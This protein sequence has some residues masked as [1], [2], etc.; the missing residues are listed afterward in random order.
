VGIWRGGSLSGSGRSS[1]PPPRP[2]SAGRRKPQSAGRQRPRSGASAA[3]KS[4]LPQIAASSSA[5]AAA[6]E[7]AVQSSYV[8]PAVQPSDVALDNVDD[9]RDQVQF[10]REFEKVSMQQ[11]RSQSEEL[12]EKNQRSLARQLEATKKKEAKLAAKN[13][14]LRDELELLKGDS[15]GADE[16]LA[17]ERLRVQN[18]Q[19]NVASLKT[20]RSGLVREARDAEEA[21]AEAEGQLED[22]RSSLDR[23]VGEKAKLEKKL[24]RE[25]K[26]LKAEQQSSK[27][28]AMEHEAIVRS[29]ASHKEEKSAVAGAK[30]ALEEQWEADRERHRCEVSELLQKVDAAQA[31]TASLQDEYDEVSTR[32]LVLKNRE[33]KR[34][35]VVRC[36]AAVQASL[37]WPEP[38]KP[39]GDT[40]AIEAAASQAALAGL[41]EKTQQAAQTAIAAATPSSGPRAV[42]SAVQR[43]SSGLSVI[44]PNSPIWWAAECTTGPSP[45]ALRSVFDSF[46]ADNSGTIDSSE[47]QKIFAKFGHTLSN[48]EVRA[49]LEVADADGSGE[50]DF[51]EFQSIV[52]SNLRNEL[53]YSAAKLVAVEAATKIQKAFEKKWPR[54]S[55]L[56]QSASAKMTSVAAQALKQHTEAVTAAGVAAAKA[57]GSAIDRRL[58]AINSRAQTLRAVTR[59]DEM[60][61][62]TKIQA[63][64]RGKRGRRMAKGERRER[65]R[66]QEDVAAVK[67]QSA[68]RGRKVRT[69]G[70]TASFFEFSLCLSRACL[71]KMFVFIYKLLKNAVFR[72]LERLSSVK[73]RCSR[74]KRQRE[75]RR[76][77]MPPPLARA[78][79]SVPLV[80]TRR[81]ER[82]AAAA[83]ADLHRVRSCGCGDEVARGRRSCCVRHWWSRHRARSGLC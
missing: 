57:Q 45:R 27:R 61:A 4:G 62:A 19:Q 11:R 28:V 1:M 26:K 50:V 48:V 58:E 9:L 10:A 17:R 72:R 52:A 63:V 30:S 13:K 67:I 12:G 32:Y 47:L 43:K 29:L 15:G 8:V 39:A 21:R 33:A 3:R 64:F 5:A 74:R 14:Q 23:A 75:N 65:K 77:Q 44:R 31:E 35:A 83:A 41:T 2:K 18:L 59:K 69:V 78:R 70:K 76:M 24:A 38:Q 34:K 60:T 82:A 36:E 71:G 25:E 20:E 46:D 79:E 53:W 51:E 7:P 73:R 66:K 22:L 56:T 40:A 49:M 42:S 54:C 80:L 37:P 6:A 55:R 68:Y 81:I 16:K